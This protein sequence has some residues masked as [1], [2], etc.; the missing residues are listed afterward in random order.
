MAD[1]I[2]YH[3]REKV[4]NSILDAGVEDIQKIGVEATHAIIHEVKEWVIDKYNKVKSSSVNDPKITLEDLEMRI[5]IS[6]EN[7][8]IG[9][10]KKE[11]AI[12]WA[13]KKLGYSEEQTQQ[14]LDLANK[15]CVRR[16]FKTDRPLVTLHPNRTNATP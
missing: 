16:R 7:V 2:K 9:M 11:I 6:N 10:E 3:R 15:A 8:D 4:V 5:K 1:K 14:V 13:M 12:M